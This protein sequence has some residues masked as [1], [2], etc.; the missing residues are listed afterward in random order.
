V[1]Y[2]KKRNQHQYIAPVFKHIRHGKH[3]QEKHMVIPAKM[4]HMAEAQVKIQPKIGHGINF[5]LTEP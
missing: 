4:E 3:Q 2:R 1:A 5:G